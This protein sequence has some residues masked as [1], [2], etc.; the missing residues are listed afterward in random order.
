MW[1]LI[2]NKPTIISALINLLIT[3]MAF[4]GTHMNEWGV[5]DQDLMRSNVPQKVTALSKISLFNGVASDGTDR[6][7]E[8][9]I[10]DNFRFG[11]D[12]LGRDLWTRTWKGRQIS[13]I[14]GVV[15]AGVDLLLG[16][17]D[18]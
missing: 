15:A 5:D 6:Y 4:V 10:E 17:I 14:I 16:V 13:L 7:A 1:W 2:R 8:R 9:Q 3:V 11:T 12:K 18:G